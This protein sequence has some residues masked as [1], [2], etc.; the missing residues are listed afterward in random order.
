ME[1]P[2]FT[3]GYYFPATNPL[4]SLTFKFHSRYIHRFKD[5]PN[6]GYSGKLEKLQL[7][8]IDATNVGTS[9]LQLP[10]IQKL[11]GYLYG[12]VVAAATAAATAQCKR[13]AT[14]NQFNLK[15]GFYL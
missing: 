10:A 8:A 1:S 3:V 6:Q 4:N 15:F 7:I 9:L 12:E 2:E 5:L 11:S 14:T 13:V